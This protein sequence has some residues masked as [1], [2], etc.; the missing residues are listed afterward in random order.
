MK[1][2]KERIIEENQEAPV[3]RSFR[4][5]REISEY[6]DELS[7]EKDISKR[8]VIEQ[9]VDKIYRAHLLGKIWGFGSG[10]EINLLLADFPEKPDYLNP[11][12]EGSVVAIGSIAPTI[13]LA[14]EGKR[15]TVHMHGFPIA[16]DGNLLLVGGPKRN[17]VTRF[18]LTD[19][20]LA[21]QSTFD[22]WKLIYGEKEYEA[23]IDADKHILQDHGLLLKAPN[24]LSPENTVM[25]IAGC[26]AFGTGGAAGL[27]A[28]KS[29][30]EELVEKLNSYC[31]YFKALVSVSVRN[32]IIVKIEVEDAKAIG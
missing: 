18:F 24:P 30:T 8:E 25:I 7:D 10:N 11:N 3:M 12:F 17:N 21:K 6:I 28:N 26:R 13:T 1:G 27:L 16:F 29:A 2:K 31:K 19:T 23:L 15:L 4:L 9:A 20:E 5:S 14:N 22:E 32:D